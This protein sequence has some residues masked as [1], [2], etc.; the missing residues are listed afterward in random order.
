ME[1]RTK[2]TWDPKFSPIRDHAFVRAQTGGHPA[3]RDEFEDV[4]DRKYA[5]GICHE[6]WDDPQI[7]WDG[8]VLGCCRN[9]WG[10]FGRSATA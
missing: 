9:F 8:K 5:S 1:F 10:D 6:L 2:L 3:T 4:H 7:N